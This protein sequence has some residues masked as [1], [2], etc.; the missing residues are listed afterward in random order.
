VLTGLEEPSNPNATDL[1]EA[2]LDLAGLLCD[3]LSSTADRGQRRD[4][5]LVRR[6]MV[7]SLEMSVGRF[8]KHRRREII[9][10]FLLLTYRD[11]AVLRQVLQDPYHPAFVVLVEMLSKIP[12]EAAMRLLLSFLDDPRAP[13]AAL[14]IVAKRSDATFVKYFL[15]KIGREPAAAVARNLK[16]IEAVAWVREAATLDLCDDQ[17]QYAAT[18][19]AMVSGIPRAHAFSLVEY[20]LLHG[21]PGGRRAA[22]EA[23]D[24]FRGADANLLAL[25][26]LDDR[27]PEV[28]A[29][30]LVQLRGRGI[31]GA[32]ARLV[33]MIDS[34][35][36][37]VRIA[38][39]KSLAEFS[40]SRYLA[41]FDLLDEE[42]R[43][44]TGDLVKKVDPQTAPLLRA[45]LGSL[46][47]SRRL[48]GLAVAQALDLTA[49]M[50]DA[51][52]PLLSDE[53]HLVRAQAATA[54][55]RCPSETAREALAGALSDRSPVVQEAARTSLRLHQ[56][57][58]VATPSPETPEDSRRAVP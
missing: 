7:G 14:S 34:P 12:H 57:A 31:P 49:D 2:L 48:R 43:V 15:R 5:H 35:H 13:S 1:G 40:F 55:A 38:A 3:D 58:A 46:V 32:L 26:A 51:V 53:D 30:I 8:A 4:V 20:L 50:E 42:V 33:E 19:L 9:E 27:D 29:K 44:S 54:L 39:R 45:E 11:D 52:V 47:R 56:A 18:R 23:L 28:Q 17:E 37:V 22:A 41:S 21:K 6:R 16:R 36:E 10:A 25:Q 24:Q